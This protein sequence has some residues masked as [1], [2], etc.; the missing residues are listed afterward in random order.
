VKRSANDP[1]LDTGND[2]TDWVAILPIGS[3]PDGMDADGVGALGVVGPAP[4]AGEDTDAGNDG[5]SP[6]A[7]EDASPGA[8]GWAAESG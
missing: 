4:S 5:A 6:A 7:S 1:G 8:A 2:A 3:A